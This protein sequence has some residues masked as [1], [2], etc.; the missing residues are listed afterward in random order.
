MT[1]GLEVLGVGGGLTGF[2]GGRLGLRAE[3]EGREPDVSPSA[4]VRR[5]VKAV[6]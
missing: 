5:G 3:A 2:W 6:I 4:R 1:R